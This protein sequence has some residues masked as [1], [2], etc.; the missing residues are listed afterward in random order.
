VNPQSYEYLN[1]LHEAILT[2]GI[3]N[4]RNDGNYNIV[5]VY[6]GQV[7]KNCFEIV[8]T[9]HGI[10]LAQTKNFAFEYFN[11]VISVNRNTLSRI[12]ALYCPS[13]DQ[14]MSVLSTNS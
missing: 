2:S 4:T 5:C 3:H 13:L 6:L 12:R 7:Y 1:L 14:F 8:H 9:S 11:D 10:C